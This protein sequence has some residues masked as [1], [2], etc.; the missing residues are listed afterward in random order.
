MRLDVVLCA[1]VK[2]WEE[3]NR[4]KES[5]S[6]DREYMLENN[7]RAKPGRTPPLTGKKGVWQSHVKFKYEKKQPTET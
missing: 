2:R 6:D 1:I 3:F 5:Y 4:T 7:G